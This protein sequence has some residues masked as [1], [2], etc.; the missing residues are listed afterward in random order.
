[1]G[2]ALCYGMKL[3]HKP[4]QSESTGLP[5]DPIWYKRYIIRANLMNGTWA[6]SRAGAHIGYAKDLDDAK[7]KIDEIAFD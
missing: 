6:I 5:T 2:F 3:T 7:A 4:G 1:M